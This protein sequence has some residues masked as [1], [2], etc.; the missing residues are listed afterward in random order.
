MTQKQKEYETVRQTERLHVLV[1]E[2]VACIVV[3]VC[4]QVVSCQ[5]GA[6]TQWMAACFTVSSQKPQKILTQAQYREAWNGGDM[7]DISLEFFPIIFV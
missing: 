3:V 2:A 4:T 1:D 6:Y 7:R 5:T